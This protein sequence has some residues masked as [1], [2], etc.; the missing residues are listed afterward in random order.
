VLT[1]ADW[2]AIGTANSLGL[3]LTAT[4]VAGNESVLIRSVAINLSPMALPGTPDLIADDDTG[5]N[6][7]N[8]TATRS[9][10]IDVPLVNSGTPV[11]VPGQVLALVDG[12]GS[13]LASHVL[14]S[15]DIAAGSY[16][17]TTSAL[18]DGTY[19]LSSRVTDGVNTVAS[20]STLTLRIDTRVP[21][22]P[23]TPALRS[24]SDTGPS[25]S[26]GIT[27]NTTPTIRVAIDGV[28]ISAAA[29]VESDVITLQEE[30]TTLGTAVLTS[31]DL[32]NGYV[33]FVVG[34]AF[35]DGSHAL[36]ARATSSANVVGPSSA[37]TTVV[38]DTSAQAA[39]G[40]PDLASAD[41]TGASSTDN[42]TSRTQ[43]RFSVS[44][45]T[46]GASV[47]DVV[48][49]LDGSTVI[50]SA[51]VSAADISANS[52]SI[53]VSGSLSS[54]SHLI[55]ARI[56]D[57]AGNPGAT[58]ASLT[59][60][61]DATTPAAP[62]LTL[63]SAS[64]SGTV[65]D[66]ITSVATASFSGTGNPGE[67]ITVY[68]GS[69]SLGTATV[70]GSGDW[71]LTVATALAD[72]THSITAKSTSVVGATSVA[73]TTSV[74]VIDTAVPAA[75]VVTAS[76]A[77]TLTPT[78]AG[79]SEAFASVEVYIDGVLAGTATANAV[80]HL[81][82]LADAIEQGHQFPVA[83]ELVGGEPEAAFAH[84]GRRFDDL[85]TEITLMETRLATGSGD[86]RKIKTAAAALAESLPTASV[87]GDVDAL[88][89]RLTAI[90]EQ[91]AQT[92]EAERARRDEQRAAQTARK[93]ALAAESEE[94]VRG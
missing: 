63:V 7:D 8:L 58:S 39:P 35:A 44:L 74:V 83:A 31:G 42:L 6:N 72:G 92:A 57:L 71:T 68:D 2:L 79:T 61:V 84:F 33:D 16:R 14:T 93:E 69:S 81:R 52:I 41:D 3:T 5:T 91:A 49:L 4:D 30:S 66:R 40:V 47:N 88:A 17:F 55:L 11:H 82:D 32:S 75:P 86:A 54:A 70:D 23:G 87:L 80:G 37:S 56:V 53:L 45:S 1:S 9:V 73:S 22:T 94:E 20:A 59:V 15:T 29:L 64:D 27:S 25:N 13:V 10:R 77:N 34:S 50:G 67:T 18:N 21:G 36:S 76:S 51:V 60:Q 90:A 12:S 89:A 46:G 26:D 28:L 62:T 65:G 19:V 43:P 78:V 24:S 48:Q 38:I 85:A